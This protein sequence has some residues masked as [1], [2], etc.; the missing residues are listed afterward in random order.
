MKA[1]FTTVRAKGG[2]GQR[3]RNS[4]T[5]LPI[6]IRSPSSRVRSPM[7]ASFTFVPFVEPRSEMTYWPSLP[8]ISACRRLAAGS[9]T[10]TSDSASLPMITRSE[11]SGNVRPGLPFS[12]GR[13]ERE[14]EPVGDPDVVDADGLVRFHLPKDPIGELDRLDT[15]P[16]GLAEDALDHALEASLELGQDSQRSRRF[17]RSGALSAFGIISTPLLAQSSTN[18][19][20]LASSMH[21]LGGWPLLPS[22][23]AQSGCG[24]IW[25]TR[26]V[27]VRVGAS[28]WRFKSSHPHQVAPP[29][30]RGW[31]SNPRDMSERA[32]SQGN[33][34]PPRAPWPE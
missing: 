22:I 14:D 11:P 31:P 8:R 30:V 3:L 25:Q 6:V 24:G 7:G 12:I 32:S 15:G 10:T 23:F 33:P 2:T 34:P 28:P 21:E 9:D 20:A 17:R 4:R 16:E 18:A 5:V 26:T 27:Q 13:R 29:L 1:H 19:S